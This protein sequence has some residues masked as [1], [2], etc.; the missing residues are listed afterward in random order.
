M[1]Y[2]LSSHRSFFC[3]GNT[4]CP[5]HLSSL[6][7]NIIYCARHTLCTLR[8]TSILMYGGGQS[9]WKLFLL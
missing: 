6:C 2:H 3:V 1:L 5:F 8:I 9:L 4:L 7:D